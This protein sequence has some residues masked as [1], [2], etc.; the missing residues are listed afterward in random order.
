MEE[1]DSEEAH[2]ERGNGRLIRGGSW[3]NNANNL[4]AAYRNNNTPTNR[5]NNIGFRAGR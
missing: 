1:T 2:R 5:N 3:N 4:R